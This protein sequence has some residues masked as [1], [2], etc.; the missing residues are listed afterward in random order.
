[1]S[2]ACST[3]KKCCKITTTDGETLQVILDVVVVT[4]KAEDIP[5]S[6]NFTVPV[7]KTKEVIEQTKVDNLPYV[8]KASPLNRAIDFLSRR[9]NTPLKRVKKASIEANWG[10]PYQVISSG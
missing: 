2:S 1:M 3:T 8:R 5:S 10:A 9:V 4:G 6:A 7:Q